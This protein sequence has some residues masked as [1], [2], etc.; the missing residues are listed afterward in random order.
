MLSKEENRLTVKT[1]A[2]RECTS[3]LPLQRLSWCQVS[4][5]E[6]R[7]PHLLTSLPSMNTFLHWIELTSINNDHIVWLLGLRQNRHGGFCLAL[8]WITCPGIMP[9]I[10]LWG[11]SSSL[12]RGTLG[13]NEGSSQQPAP[14]CQPFV[15]ANLAAGPPPQSRLRMAASWPACEC[16]LNRDPEPDLPS[17]IRLSQFLTHKKWG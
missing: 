11:H 2:K 14:A 12:R 9:G 10:M 4:K 16:S 5:K 1:R 8:S 15:Q 3:L 7:D 13:G 17:K 6:P